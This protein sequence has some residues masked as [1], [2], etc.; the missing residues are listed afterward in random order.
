MWMKELQEELSGNQKLNFEFAS[1]KAIPNAW[2]FLKEILSEED[3]SEAISNCITP[4]DQT[5][6]NSKFL[7]VMQGTMIDFCLT[8]FTQRDRLHAVYLER[9]FWVE[10]VIPMFK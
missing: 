6:H 5:S 2:D 1:L 7:L 8:Y 9:K 4:I 3:Q 10:S